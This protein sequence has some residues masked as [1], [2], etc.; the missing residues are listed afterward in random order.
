MSSVVATI[1][2]G[3]GAR[4]VPVSAHVER[5]AEAAFVVVG[6]GR[7][8]RE[9]LHARL[10][11]AVLSSGLRWPSG[12][13]VVDADPGVTGAWD[14]GVDLA[15]GLAVLAADGQLEV[16]TGERW[17]AIGGLR[18]DGRVEPV[19]GVLARLQA[20]AGLPVVLPA[21]ALREISSSLAPG[22]KGAAGVG[23]LGVDDL[24]SLVTTFRDETTRPARRAPSLGSASAVPIERDR[25]EGDR[26]EPDLAD[27]AGEARGRWALEVAAAGGHHLLL[28]GP[29]G[30]GKTM[31]A[32]RLAGLLPDL[33][34]GW[35]A[36]VA[37]IASAADSAGPECATPSRPTRPPVRQVGP[38]TSRAAL[39]GGTGPT[40]R[41]GLVSL[42]H[43][44]VLV[45]EDLWLWDPSLLLVVREALDRGRLEVTRGPEF[46]V[47]PARFQLVAT[48]TTRPAGSLGWVA[49]LERVRPSGGAGLHA[50]LLDRF[51]LVV[52]VTSPALALLGGGEPSEPSAVVAARVAAA[53]RRAQD[54]LAALGF[55]GES[56][57]E[58]AEERRG[59]ENG[60]LVGPALRI[61]APLAPGATRLLRSWLSGGEIGVRGAVSLQRVARTIADLTGGEE[62]VSAD[63]LAA[64]RA[65]RQVESAWRR[66]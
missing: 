18:L 5:E 30:A 66:P 38:M 28:A 12:R 47:L 52:A 60:R 17:V 46:F 33:P 14:R 2:S 40:G 22:E 57:G 23:L 11:A 58:G 41:P 63:H 7:A 19:A 53:R 44:G 45:A 50:G 64:A 59:E 51:D 55:S 26:I 4:L 31:L 49:P 15:V 3:A 42:A 25:A 56:S 61:L 24:R 8:S 36:E 62:R 39:A 1:L 43:R 10:R 16:T 20:A 34:S 32:E 9:A 29:P 48:V 27:V 21:E 54:R 65:L 35:A 13:V 37:A 6:L